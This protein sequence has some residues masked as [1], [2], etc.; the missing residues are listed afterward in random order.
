MRACESKPHSAEELD[1]LLETRTPESMSRAQ[2]RRVSMPL[3]IHSMSWCAQ[4]FF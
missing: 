2:N 4:S 1:L 3:W